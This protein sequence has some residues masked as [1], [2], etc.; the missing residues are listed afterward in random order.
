MAA[1]RVPVRAASTT[2]STPPSSASPRLGYGLLLAHPERVTTARSSRLAP[3]IEAGALLQVNVSS[4]LGDHGPRR[5]ADRRARWCRPAAPTAW[6]PTP[7]PARASR[8]SRSAADALRRARRQRRA[9]LPPHAV[10][11]A[12]PPARGQSRGWRSRNTEDRTNTHPL[13]GVSSVRGTGGPGSSGD[14]RRAEPQPGPAGPDRRRRAAAAGLQHP[15]RRA[16]RGP[17]G[18]HPRPA[19][20][21]RRARR[22]VRRGHPD[23]AR[24]RC[25]SPRGRRSACARGSASRSSAPAAGSAT[26]GCSRSRRSAPSE[27]RLARAAAAEAAALVG[28]DADAQLVRRR[29]EQQLVTALLSADPAAGRDRRGTRS[30]PSTTCRCG[31]VRVWVAAPAGPGGGGVERGGAGPAARAARGQAGAVRR[32]RRRLVCLAG[33]RGLAGDAVMEALGAL[34]APR[35]LVG[36]GEA[37]ERPARG[38]H[39]LPARAGGA[40]GRGARGVGHRELGRA[41]RGA[42]RHGAPGLGARGPTGRAA[43]AAGRRPVARADAR[44]LPR[45]RGRRQ[46]HGRGA[47]PAPRRA[48]LP[49][50]PDRGGGRA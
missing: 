26:C 3:H 33:V 23:G 32:A 30:R 2:T 41:R 28:P 36:Q 11:P 25:T 24:R 39:V 49:P 4:L 22:A 1:A 40:A 19:R 5:A 46:A 7:T 14:R 42:R 45:S 47:V 10:Q 17:H 8:S 6:P 50:A 38:G 43:E 18:Q 21:R 37:V 15:V 12:L 9:G 13:I 35:A 29:H 20:A 44:G 16:R 27:L 31:R 48:L 34:T